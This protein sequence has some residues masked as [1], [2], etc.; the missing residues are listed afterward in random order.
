MEFSSFFLRFFLSAEGHT[1]QM[2]ANKARQGTKR[3]P[4]PK[5]K[6]SSERLLDDYLFVGDQDHLEEK[7]EQGYCARM[8]FPEPG[9]GRGKQGLKGCVVWFVEVAVI[10]EADSPFNE[11]PRL[12]G[13]ND[14]VSKTRKEVKI[15]VG[16]GAK[17]VVRTCKIERRLYVKTNFVRLS[18]KTGRLKECGEEFFVWAPGYKVDGGTTN[19]SVNHLINTIWKA[20]VILRTGKDNTSSQTNIGIFF[21]SD[22]ES[23]GYDSRKDLGEER[24]K[25]LHWE[26]MC[27][28]GKLR[29]SVTPEWIINNKT[30]EWLVEN[31]KEQ[32]LRKYM[33]EEWCRYYLDGHSEES[34]NEDDGNDGNDEREQDEEVRSFRR[35]VMSSGSRQE[36]INDLEEEFQKLVE[37]QEFIE[38]RLEELRQFPQVGVVKLNNGLVPRM[39]YTT[40]QMLHMVTTGALKLAQCYP[41]KGTKRERE[42]SVEPTEKKHIKAHI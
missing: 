16:T 27:I 29:G 30:S 36:E 13:V 12:V 11:I 10:R 25:W 32:W 39:T 21:G 6:T 33:S 34:E 19:A 28:T 2:A 20:E 35:E 31:R 5:I 17:S 18:E 42:E 1:A 22:Y 14:T 37:R 41:K 9:T 7:L 15:R 3:G 8:V 4:S 26:R 40:S 24:R 23:I 38:S